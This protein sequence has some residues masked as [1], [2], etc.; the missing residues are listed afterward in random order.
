MES[1]SKYKQTSPR[2]ENKNAD[3]QIFNSLKAS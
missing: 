3:K 1:L 2:T